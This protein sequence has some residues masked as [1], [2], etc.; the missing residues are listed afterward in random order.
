MKMFIKKKLFH[1]IFLIFT[2]HIIA[3]VSFLDGQNQAKKVEKKS[4]DVSKKV[5]PKN[6]KKIKVIEKKPVNKSIASSKRKQANSSNRIKPIV[7]T[8]KKG[9]IFSKSIEEKIAKPSGAPLPKVSEKKEKVK[10]LNDQPEKESSVSTNIDNV[11]INEPGGNWLKKRI[12]WQ[13]AQRKIDKIEKSIKVIIN[14]NQ[15]FLKKRKT[16]NNEL[17]D[18]F[19]IEIGFKQGQL[20]EVLNFLINHMQEQRKEKIALNKTEKKVLDKLELKKDL[21][22]KL[23][24][25]VDIVKKID[26]AISDALLQLSDQVNKVFT[27]K[28]EAQEKI[29]EIANVLDPE[30]A[31]ELYYQMDTSWQN[32]KGVEKYIAQDFDKHFQG[33]LSKAKEQVDEVRKKVQNLKKEGVVL[34]D[35]IQKIKQ[36]EKKKKKEEEKKKLLLKKQQQEKEEMERLA[37]RSFFEKI[38]DGASYYFVIISDFVSSWWNFIIE[39]IKGADSDKDQGVV[40]DSKPQKKPL[41]NQKDIDKKLVKKK[42]PATKLPVSKKDNA[43]NKVAPALKKMQDQK[44]LKNDLQSK[45]YNKKENKVSIGSQPLNTKAVKDN[46]KK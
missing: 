8:V 34:K 39:K 36:Q 38:V 42:V 33:L 12:W 40:A 7:G 35:E 11:S 45:K 37:Q 21:L 1:F 25:E 22:Q 24:K 3:P 4:L 15:P 31:K 18:P 28:Q 20:E 5:E 17:F 16:V 23:K 29:K 43:T 13:E 30:K 46:K 27:Y 9:P 19:Y 10:V 6:Q 2:L 26:T 41:H 14:S 44:T 32:I